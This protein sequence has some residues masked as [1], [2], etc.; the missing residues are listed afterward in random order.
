MSIWGLIALLS[1]A[2]CL[3][4]K[5]VLGLRHSSLLREMESDKNVC[6]DIRHAWE[7]LVQQ[8]KLLALEEKQIKGQIKSIKRNLATRTTAYVDLEKRVKQVEEAVENQRALLKKPK[9]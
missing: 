4:I 9:E 5:W 2:I 3:V 1:V 8:R 6:R 7:A